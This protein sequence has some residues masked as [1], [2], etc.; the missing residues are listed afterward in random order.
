MKISKSV[1]LVIPVLLTLNCKEITTTTQ[2][3]K[4]GS[5]QRIVVV[6]NDSENLS[7]GAFPIPSDSTWQIEHKRDE[8]DSSKW[9]HTLNKKFSDI[10]ALQQAYTTKSDTAPTVRITFEMDKRFRWFF[11]F[12]TFRETLGA[13]NPFNRLPIQ[14][15]LTDSEI[16]LYFADSDSGDI[17]KK[18]EDWESKA[19]M[20]DFF[21]SL[22]DSLDRRNEPQLDPVRIKAH[23]DQ[24]A[25]ALL[26]ENGDDKPENIARVIAKKVGIADPSVLTEIIKPIMDEINRKIDFTMD[27][28]SNTYSNTVIMPGLLIDSS[29]PQ[30][31]GNSANW[32]IN[33]GQFYH[34]DFTMMAESRVVNFWPIVITATL[35][36][37]GLLSWLLAIGRAKRAR[38]S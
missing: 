27:V 18:F 4:D 33:I 16:E 36:L 8:T 19:I 10:K 15:Y 35:A 3:Y 9:I 6:K 32:K 25:T 30:I 31:V 22:F 5:C 38:R 37:L 24:I 23:Q 21:Q 17:K 34:R 14:D 28:R 2:V 7:V 29:A 26:S 1:L 13:F 20:E 12:F 11:T